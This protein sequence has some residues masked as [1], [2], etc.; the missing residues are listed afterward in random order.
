LHLG[1]DPPKDRR[2]AVATVIVGYQNDK[3]KAG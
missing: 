2:A 1:T 3:S